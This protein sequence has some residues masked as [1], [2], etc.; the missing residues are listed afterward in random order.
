MTELLR[1]EPGSL[2]QDELDQRIA[3]VIQQFDEKHYGL[4]Q[5]QGNAVLIAACQSDQKAA[6]ARFGET[7]S[8]ALTYH[9]IETLAGAGGQM[10]YSALIAG[11]T[12]K[13]GP[14]FAQTPQLECSKECM[15]LPFLHDPIG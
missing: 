9:L 5:M 8:G 12:Q 2:T 11:L 6:D 3:A 4:E 13:M 15:D 10:P 14:Q 1:R 7:Y